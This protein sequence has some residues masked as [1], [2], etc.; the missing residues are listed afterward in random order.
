MKIFISWSKDP[1]KTIATE[2]KHFIESTL[3]GV[4]VWMSDLDIAKGDRWNATVTE[5]LAKTDIGIICCTKN[6][7]LEPWLHFEAGALSKSVKHGKIFPLCFGIEFGQLPTTLGQFQGTMF[8]EPDV[9]RLVQDINEKRE[10]KATS[11]DLM[12]KFKRQWPL[13]K[14]AVDKAI[15]QFASTT[16]SMPLELADQAQPEVVFTD[17]ELSILKYLAAMGRA[18]S[19]SEIA[20]A[21]SLQRVRAEHWLNKLYDKDYVA[22]RYN[23]MSGKDYLLD[24]LGMELAV[25]K[26][27]V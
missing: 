11:T 20:D 8:T 26:D 24:E 22:C 16:S 9:F 4:G 6:S 2:I 21:T 13:V 7:V 19:L 27:W 3:P 15:G 12:A 1:S 23:M 17:D 25:V 14:Q 5:Q 18:V 10:N